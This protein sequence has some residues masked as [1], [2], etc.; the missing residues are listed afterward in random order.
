MDQPVNSLD[1]TKLQMLVDGALSHDHRSELLRGLDDE[2]GAWRQIAIG[3][4]EKQLLDETLSP[5]GNPK[6]TP[7]EIR[8][9]VVEYHTTRSGPSRWGWLALAACLAI[10]IGLG[11]LIPRDAQPPAVAQNTDV[12]QPKAKTQTDDSLRLEDALARSIQPV[13][14]DA[15]RQFLRAGYVVNES[16]KVADVTLPTGDLIQ[17]PV[18]QVTVKYLGDAAFQ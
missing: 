11:S 4:L 16:Q 5:A 13:S 3:F 17:M 8:E 12:R 18:R 10:G 6:M 2:P 9:P 15:H 1:P 7:T 14:L